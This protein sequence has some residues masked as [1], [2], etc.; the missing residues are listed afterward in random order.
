[1]RM[2]G[3]DSG[4]GGSSGGGGGPGSLAVSIAG[5][6]AGGSVPK[7]SLVSLDLGPV[8]TRAQWCKG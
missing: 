7:C 4:G 3:G 6:W 1:M 8:P 5:G 2:G